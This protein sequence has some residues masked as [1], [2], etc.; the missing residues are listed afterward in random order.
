MTVD[1]SNSVL[2]TE[3]LL[4]A[5]ATL[6]SDVTSINLSGNKLT[7]I[8]NLTHLPNL[9]CVDLHS[10]KINKITYL[11]YLVNLK[12]LFIYKN[13]IGFINVANLPVSLEEICFSANWSTNIG[14]FAKWIK[15]VSVMAYR[16]IGIDF[17][18]NFPNATV[19]VNTTY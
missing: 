1:L 17:S 7:E 18:Y 5:I 11:G 19:N 8:P 16:E 9:V 15:K 4:S 3:A 12:H 14:G 10:N 13:P 2:N 6:P